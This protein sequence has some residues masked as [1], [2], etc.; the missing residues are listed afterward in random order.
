MFFSFILVSSEILLAFARSLNFA[1]NWGVNPYTL[2]F[3]PL[4]GHVSQHL[5]LFLI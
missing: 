2:V 5:V 3:R 1:L 4:E